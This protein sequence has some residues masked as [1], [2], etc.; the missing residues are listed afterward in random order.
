MSAFRI[1]TR[2]SRLHRSPA[3]HFRC[4]R[5]IAV[6]TSIEME[7]LGSEVMPEG[8]VEAEPGGPTT[9][10][11]F[12]LTILDVIAVVT[13]IALCTAYGSIFL[14]PSWTPRLMVILA[15]APV[16][17]ALLVRQAARRDRVA[18]VSLA[19]V[20]WGIFASCLAA[21]PVGSIIGRV[22][23]EE[24]GL[25][26]AASLGLLALGR[27]LSDRGRVAVSW[28]ALLGVSMSSIVGVLQYVAQT[29]SGAFAMVAGRS[30]GLTANP[31]YF[32]ACAAGA[33]GVLVARTASS[34]RVLVVELSMAAL[35]GTA[36]S[37]SAAR[38]ALGAAIL[39]AAAHCI[40]RRNRRVCGVSGALLSGLGSG[41]LLTYT[42]GNG[43]NSVNR[44]ADGG[45]SRSTVWRYGLDALMER[46]IQGWGFGEF[47][48]A[49]QGRITVEHARSLGVG[50]QSEMFDAHNSVVE[51]A[52]A[53][54][55]VGL[56]IAGVLAALVCRRAQ[57]P[58]AV[59][60][61]GLS[62]SWL[63]QP[64]GFA[65]FPLALLLVGAALPNAT[66]SMDDGLTRE[67]RA[68]V[69]Y[70]WLLVP[71]LV[72]AALI[73]IVDVVASQRFE[74]GDNGGLAALVN[75]VP[76]DAVLADSVA[77]SYE[78]SLKD[79]DERAG[80]EALEW[81]V[82]ATEVQPDRS[83]WWFR[84]GLLEATLGDLDAALVSADQ[85]LALEPNSWTAIEL[86]MRILDASG[87]AKSRDAL[88][89]L[90]CALAVPSCEN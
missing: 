20:A 23:I 3:F 73:G 69:R 67:R 22:G 78:S 79:G 89:P 68:S 76:D 21:N 34:R 52:V 42:V 25:A 74:M 41:T 60:A 59:G 48:T 45:A 83:R 86:K 65:T 46:P 54:G 31:V 57:G 81:R 56:V 10:L 28:A 87:D 53:M 9:G 47:R 66:R 14:L 18:M 55:V 38:V 36:I 17:F 35:F 84:R 6:L 62:L 77:Q 27:D 16:G 64:M 71:G 85:A 15:A 49:V 19:V 61:L 29:D 13:A 82:R 1:R 50:M 90:A 24:S 70:A 51:V 44:L 39:L 75:A 33:F 26:L 63:L 80:P 12:G 5:N 88:M 4:F 40:M 7:T 58:L 72:A 43:L 11:I 8:S 2:R 32:G 30:S 37:L